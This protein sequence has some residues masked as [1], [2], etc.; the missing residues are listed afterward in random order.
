MTTTPPGTPKSQIRRHRASEP[1]TPQGDVQLLYGM[2]EPIEAPGSPSPAPSSTKKTR[3]RANSNNNGI[4]A[5]SRSISRVE[6]TNAGDDKNSTNV[7]RAELQSLLKR[8]KG[9][10]AQLNDLVFDLEKLTR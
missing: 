3:K 2:G 8:A 5:G 6:N 10:Q 1:Q 4:S 9:M 7:S